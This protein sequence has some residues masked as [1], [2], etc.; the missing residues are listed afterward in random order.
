MLR[1]VRLLA[2]LGLLAASA[3]AASAC[4]KSGPNFFLG[5]D[6][7]R[8]W[9]VK[10]GETCTHDTVLNSGAAAIHETRIVQ[11][12]KH[13]TAGTNGHTSYAYK[14]PAKYVGPDRFAVRITGE[15]NGA[16]AS[17]VITV[18]VDVRP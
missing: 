9:I 8:Q 14:A 7:T 13:G 16:K 1:T 12:A 18:D 17:T 3:D 11:R 10:P 4:Q 15:R 5:G 6:V 2:V